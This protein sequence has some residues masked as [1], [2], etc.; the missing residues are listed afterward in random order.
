VKTHQLS[1]NLS[2]SNLYKTI[3]PKSGKGEKHCFVV[4][5]GYFCVSTTHSAAM[6]KLYTLTLLILLFSTAQVS[7]IQTQAQGLPP[8][9]EIS[10]GS[11]NIHGMIVY[12]DA[13]P[14]VNDIPLQP[15]DYIGTFYLNDA[16]E[17]V[18]AGA[19]FWLGDENIIFTVFG[20]D[21]DTPEKDGFAYA[22]VMRIKVFLWSTQK[23][24]DTDAMSWDS[25]MPCTTKWYPMCLSGMTNLVCSVDFDAYI[26][27][28]PQIICTGNTVTLTANIFEGT[29]GNYTYN[30]W[31][32][33]AGALNNEISFTDTPQVTTAYFLEVS[34]GLLTSTHSLTVV[35]NENPI[36]HAGN[37]ATIC[38]ECTTQ[39]AATTEHSSS[40][41]WQTA[42]DGTFDDASLADAK[43][44]PGTADI[45]GHLVM[46]AVTAFPLED[47]ML[48]HADTLWITIPPNPTVGL[49]P[50]SQ[51]C[52]GY[53]IIADADAQN[54][55]SV[56]WTTSGDGTFA[57]PTQEVTEYFPGSLDNSIRTFT[58]S[59]CVT[60]IPP[61]TKVVCKSTQA[62][63]FLAPVLNAQTVATQCI[64]KPIKVNSIAHNH[65]SLQ[66]S[67]NG[68][69]T[70]DNS[71]LP[72]T[73]YYPGAADNAAGNAGL[74]VKA[75]G[76]GGCG[77]L[78]VSKAVQV[79]IKKSPMAYAG[80]DA[81]VCNGG[82][83]WLSQAT[84]SNNNGLSWTTSGDGYFSNRYTLNPTYTPGT[85]DKSNGSCRLSLAAN[86]VNPCTVA[87][88]DTLLL[89]LAGSP[90]ISI[91][92]AGNQTYPAA[93]PLD[94][95]VE[96][97]YAAAF[98][99]ETSGDG[100]F[101]N[102]AFPETLYYPGTMDASGSPVVL[103]IT[104]FATANC[105]TD[106][107]DLINVNFTDLATISAGSDFVACQDAAFVEGTTQ[108][109]QNV[110][111]QTSGD[112]SFAD[113]QSHLT[114]YFPGIDDLTQGTIQLS[115]TGYF[116]S[117]NS[118]TDCVVANI[119]AN[120]NINIITEEIHVCYDEI[121]V[122]LADEANYYSSVYWYTTN[123]GGVFGNNGTLNP[124]Y[125]P[126][127]VT[128]YPQG[129]ITI[130]AA[131][132]PIDPCTTTAED[133]LTV[134]FHDTPQAFAGWDYTIT[135]GQ[136]W[137][138]DAS[139]TAAQ[140]VLWHTSGDGNFDDAL[141]IDAIYFPGDEDIANSQVVLMLTAFP[142]IA[143]AEA[144]TDE[145]TLT[146]HQ[147]QILEIPNGWSG[148]SS[149][150]QTN[151]TVEELLQPIMPN[152]VIAQNLTGAFWPQGGINSLG[153]F[154]NYEGYK[155]RV[156][157]PSQLVLTGPEVTNKTIAFN[158]GWNIM[159]VLSE[160]NLYHN[161]ITNQIGNKLVV[162][163]DIGGTGVLWPQMGIYTLAIFQPGL[164]YMVC[165]NEP[166]TAIYPECP[167]YKQTTLAQAVAVPNTS[168]WPEPHATQRSH[169]I[170]F[171]SLV[172][173]QFM[174]EDVIGAFDQQGICCGVMP[175]ANPNQNQVMSIFGKDD[176]QGIEEGELI[177]L[178]LF[179]AQSGE[180]SNLT[181][182]FDTNYPS[183]DGRYATNGISVID[184][185]EVSDVSTSA[186]MR[187]EPLFHPNPAHEYINISASFHSENA[188][189]SI[190]DASGKLLI[191]NASYS[192]P[193]DISGL[194]P[195]FYLVAIVTATGKHVGKLVV[196]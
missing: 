128:D 79:V 10:D 49:P 82:N 104:A 125:Y 148:F 121:V 111:W 162:M 80:E 5:V 136:S 65:S 52:L 133:T 123:G 41:M 12:L 72:I 28:T 40:L 160:C 91:T 25:E 56:L 89:S 20:D 2:Q 32:E 156:T 131:A 7:S 159:P 11:S 81:L 134:C 102:N 44:F 126:A 100:T 119:A 31:S 186:N 66:W 106:A 90:Q 127:P 45:Q 30:W 83:L 157:A 155:I 26:S 112:G 122:L 18:C 38:P 152:V 73:W 168:P 58:L 171:T 166:C 78:E 145:L 118:L 70:F 192:S 98:L 158:P 188:L 191:K 179:Q 107:T 85:Q 184:N 173:Q 64:N 95:L 153:A 6:K 86:P 9:W 108:N 61:L 167:V 109:C 149:Y 39:L 105:G 87:A 183:N 175:V 135:K 116:G 137:S 69:G 24:Y 34:D 46:L 63:I 33:P 181:A 139:V 17:E 144:D 147:Q 13:N 76:A 4:P 55:S 195:G 163:K 16:G 68:D 172:L 92:T 177:T 22:E 96:A 94:L 120:A 23:A 50:T 43:Y 93:Q 8:G 140:S 101:A 138:P 74:T 154:N 97:S 189:V 19:D 150:I 59:A 67:T 146:I 115:L 132:L 14:R 51:Y 164:A 187:T 60:A 103:S 185:I 88:I 29:T 99:W 174:A 113:P 178:K 27:A 110:L 176:N 57:N 1:L 3:F 75:F 117:G 114:Q 129:C 54:F 182:G 47:C 190:G 169:L 48:T 161:D 196:E 124:V 151:M 21:Q 141:S 15:G 53:A 193:I 130:I 62:T 180:I 71:S 143:C 170:A 35:V 42:G 142:E 36:A 37:D 194:T 84:V 165:V 77:M